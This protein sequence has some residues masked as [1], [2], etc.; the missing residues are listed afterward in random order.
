MTIIFVI[1]FGWNRIEIVG[2]VAF[3]ILA[4]IGSHVN[5]N[6]KKNRKNLKIQIFEKR[7]KKASRDIADR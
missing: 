4:P 3:E 7:K 6:K 5:E 1:K 2:E